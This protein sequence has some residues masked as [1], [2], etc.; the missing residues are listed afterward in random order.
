MSNAER[1]RDLVALR[2]ELQG[3]ATRTPSP[4]K[5]CKS[6]WKGYPGMKWVRGKIEHVKH[7]PE[8]GSY[9]FPISDHST[10]ASDALTWDDDSDKENRS[11]CIRPR[12]CDCSPFKSYKS[13]FHASQPYSPKAS[14]SS[15]TIRNSTQS[16]C[17]AP[18]PSQ[19][20]SRVGPSLG[21]FKESQSS[22]T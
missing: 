22:Q 13:P 21:S 1:E 4:K 8:G 17:K 16:P 6:Y 11:P 14:T 5:K 10:D 12:F 9:T 20:R 19:Y 18:K 15:N 7:Y 2:L 3:P